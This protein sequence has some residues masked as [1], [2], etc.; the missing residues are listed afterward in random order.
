MMAL[1]F[2]PVHTGIT[3]VAVARLTMCPVVLLSTWAECLRRWVCACKT[4]QARARTAG[5]YDAV[6]LVYWLA[7]KIYDLK[8]ALL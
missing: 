1:G 6:W 8:V 7:I 5:I 3:G 2:M 4:H